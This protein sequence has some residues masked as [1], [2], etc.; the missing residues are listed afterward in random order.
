MAYQICNPLLPSSSPSPSPSPSPLPSPSPSPS[1]SH[2]HASAPSVFQFEN[3]RLQSEA[4]DK[5]DADHN[6]IPDVQVRRAW[7]IH[8]SNL[9]F[10]QR[11]YF[12]W[13][14]E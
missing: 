12:V 13:I 2:P 1:P 4:D 5:I 14:I 7:N 9:K 3:A 10:Y 6:N 8:G 11:Y